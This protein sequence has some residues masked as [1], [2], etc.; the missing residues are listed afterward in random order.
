MLSLIKFPR[1]FSINQVPKVFHED[2]IISGYRHPRSSAT[3]C[4]LSLFQMTNETLNIWTHFLPTWYFLWKLVTVVL[5]QQGWQDTFT[6]PLLVFL[7]SCCIYPLASSCAHTFSTM[8]LRARHICFF[9]D[10]GALS[11]YSLGSAIVYSLYAFP[12]KWLNSSF[13]QWYIPIAV[14]NTVICT[15]LA[16]YSRLPESP[17]FSKFLRI[18]AFAYPYLFDNIPLFYRVFLCTGD[19]CTNND[20]NILHYKHI[21]LAFLTGFLFATH[22][23]ERLAP[24][25]FDYIGHSHQLFHVC[26][27]LGTHF[28]MLAVEQDMVT[29]RPWLTVNSIPI[30][31]ANSMGPAVLCVVLNLIIILLFSLPLFSGPVC[32]ESKHGKDKE[33]VATKGCSCY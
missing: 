19:G 28:Q 27:I 3:D 5:M 11:L 10:Y 30:S 29:R 17:K 8:S 14:A 32:K 21:S 9:F 16:C 18:L 24:G 7:S 25:S 33:K 4:I 31:S 22:L 26:G 23:P 1:I 12:D 13:H 2:S 6:W 15:V 20:T